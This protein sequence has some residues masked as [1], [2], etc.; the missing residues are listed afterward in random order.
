MPIHEDVQMGVHVVRE[1]LLRVGRQP[2]LPRE[3]HRI[4]G[5]RDH[6][7]I[8]R[9]DAAVDG[10]EATDEADPPPQAATQQTQRTTD[11]RG[12]SIARILPPST[13]PPAPRSL[14][15]RADRVR[16][17]RQYRDSRRSRDPTPITSAH[18]HALTCGVWVLTCVPFASADR[19]GLTR[20]PQLHQP[21]EVP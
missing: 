3:R 1:V 7:G 12:H 6:E 11:L 20:L 14:S 21:H 17:R 15:S 13:S 2:G 18:P 10:V 8:S 4:G 19:S 16:S 5:K 9:S